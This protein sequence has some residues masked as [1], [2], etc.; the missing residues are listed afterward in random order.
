MVYGMAVLCG[1]L[2]WDMYSF[3]WRVN[4]MVMVMVMG[5]WVV[6]AAL[7]KTIEPANL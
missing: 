3:D 4:M 7:V 6:D 5:G 1:C 2:A